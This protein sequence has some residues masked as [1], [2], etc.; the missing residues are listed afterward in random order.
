MILLVEDSLSAREATQA[1]LEMSGYQVLTA[2]N[3]R[4]AIRLARDHQ[5]ELDL[6]LSDLVMPEMGGVELYHAVKR[7][8][9][10]IQVMIMTG[11]PLELEGRALLEEGIVNWIQKP[12]SIRQLTDQI[13][14]L[15]SQ[16]V[17]SP[18]YPSSA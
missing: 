18:L 15:L 9:P 14:N 4:E 5:A 7:I 3:G 6:V 10:A 8:N 17:A 13:G 1:I 2:A 16:R 11:Y 12:F